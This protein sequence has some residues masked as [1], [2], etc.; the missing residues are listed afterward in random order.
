MRH[1]I[2]AARAVKEEARTRLHAG[3]SLSRQGVDLALDEHLETE[4][5]DAEIM[6]FVASAMPAG[7]CYVVLSANVCTA[8]LR[9]IAWAVASAPEVIVK[10]SRRDPVLAELLC[11]ALGLRIASQIDPEPGDA[12][13]IYGSDETIAA[14]ASALPD[15][16]HIVAHGTGIG[17]AVG[18]DAAAIAG[19]L[20]VFDGAGC[21]SPR[22]AIAEDPRA[23]AGALHEALLDSDIPRG[24]VDRAALARYRQTM[25][26]VGGVLEGPHHLVAFDEAP[27]AIALPP[28]HRGIIVVPPSAA[29]LLPARHIAAIGGSGTLCDALAEQCPGARRSALGKMQ[30]PPFDGPVDRRYALET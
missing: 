17:V 5:S 4:P 10:P 25:K 23:F 9:A 27:R 21:L 20:I 22:V 26:V 30:K 13:H 16:V 6:A 19:D 2:E 29:A 14:I 28:A 24:R 7:R 3:G 1:V 12:L 15:G 18:D 11:Y 8:A